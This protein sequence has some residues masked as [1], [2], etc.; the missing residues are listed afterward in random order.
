MSLI[1][2]IRAAHCRPMVLRFGLVQTQ[3]RPYMLIFVR[4]TH[5]R[6]QP[7]GRQ[8]QHHASDVEQDNGLIRS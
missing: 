4:R 7:H 8:V 5:K 6:V 1:D 3:S 2:T